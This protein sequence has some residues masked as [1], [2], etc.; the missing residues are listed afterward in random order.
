[1]SGLNNNDQDFYLG[2]LALSERLHEEAEKIR[3]E[4]K[5]YSQIIKNRA[6]DS[7]FFPFYI[8]A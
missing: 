5:G 6:S 1:M 2:L 3:E 8:G 7:A 4:R